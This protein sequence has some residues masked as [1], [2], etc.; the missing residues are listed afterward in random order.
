[1]TE[2]D[3]KIIDAT[4]ALA[5]EKGWSEVALRDIAARAALP[6]SELYERAPGKH[7][8]LCLLARHVNQT[9][10]N[11]VGTAPDDTESPRERLFEVLMARFDALKPF[12]PG[13]KAIVKDGWRDPCAA[14]LLAMMV[15]PGMAWMLE[16]AGINT[17]G[18]T[19]PTKVL[20]LSGL[21]ARALR[22]WMDDETED[23]A[24]TMAELDRLLKQA[25]GWAISMGSKRR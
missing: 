13:L 25:E 4:L 5:V 22:V 16:A 11:S 14:G 23:Q 6:M 12:K 21:Y 9:A 3:I 20:A 7:A 1:M 8:V 17:G 24:K 19:G 2:N 15:P 10:L 18:L